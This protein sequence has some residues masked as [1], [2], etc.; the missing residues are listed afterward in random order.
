[1]NQTINE[2]FLLEGHRKLFLNT[3][4]LFFEGFGLYLFP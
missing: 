1:M 2:E 3:V 4:S